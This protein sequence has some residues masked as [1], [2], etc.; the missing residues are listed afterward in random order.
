MKRAYKF[1]AGNSRITPVGVAAAVCAALALRQQHASWVPAVFLG[2]LLLT[3]AASTF[4]T[5]Q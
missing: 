1:I 5:V 3:L 2:I 4:E